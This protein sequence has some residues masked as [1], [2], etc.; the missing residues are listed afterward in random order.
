MLGQTL[1][2]PRRIESSW[3]ETAGLGLLPTETVFAPTKQ[4]NQVCAIVQ[5]DRHCPGSRGRAVEG[6]EIHLGQTTG[7]RPWLRISHRGGVV[8]EAA[9][10][11]ISEDGRIWGCYLHGLFANDFF[12][13]AWLDSLGGRRATPLRFQTG[14]RLRACRTSSAARLE[15]SLNRLADCVENALDMKKLEQIARNATGKGQDQMPD[16]VNIAHKEKMVR[17]D[18]A[19]EQQD[20]A[21]RRRRD[22]SSCIPAPA[23]ERRQ[24]P[25]GWRSAPSGRD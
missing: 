25:W 13:R 17:R 19:F 1:R 21:G 11:A 2:D 14:K 12:R 8:V 23:R 20:R 22:C 6:Y 24:R 3:A 10:G 5:D 16:D 4:T 15:Q 18:E 9:D 7:P